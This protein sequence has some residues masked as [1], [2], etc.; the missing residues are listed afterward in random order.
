M[1]NATTLI[2]TLVMIAGEIHPCCRVCADFGGGH[3]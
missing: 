2:P 1:G 3:G